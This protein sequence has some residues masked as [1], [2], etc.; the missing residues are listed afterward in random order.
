MEDRWT[1]KPGSACGSTLGEHTTEVLR[2][3]LGYDADAIRKVI[4]YG[5]DGSET[6]ALSR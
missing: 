3:V 4:S 1:I 5:D 2:E 6:A